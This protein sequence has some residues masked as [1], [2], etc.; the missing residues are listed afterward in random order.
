VRSCFLRCAKF[1]SYVYVGDELRFV[2][3]A[4]DERLMRL[5]FYGDLMSSS[6]VRG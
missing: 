3:L 1:A 4:I 2:D 6:L 5:G